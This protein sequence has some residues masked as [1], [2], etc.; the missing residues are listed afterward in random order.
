MRL[1]DEQ[2]TSAQLAAYRARGYVN[3]DL[4]PK[5]GKQRSMSALNF[6]TLWMQSVHNIPNYAAVGACLVMGCSPLHVMIAIL[7]GAL[8]TAVIMITNGVV[9]SRYGIPASMHL[10]TVYGARGA[11]LPGVLRGVVAALCWYG[12]QTYIGA[13]TLYILLSKLHPR[14]VSFG[15]EIPFIG[16][17]MPI[18]VCFVG[19]WLLNVLL[20]LGG[21][22]ILNKMTA[23]LSVMIYVVF[24]AMTLWALHVSGGFSVIMHYRMS[25]SK[26]SSYGFVLV[27]IIVVNMIVASWSAPIVSIADFT[28]HSRST[29][30]QLIG[31][32]A[33]F[34]LSYVLFAFTSV[35]IIIGGSIAYQRALPNVLD[36]INRWDNLVAI[37]IATL[38]LL[39]TTIVTNITGNIIPAA[40][41]ITALLPRWMTYKRAVVV[42]SIFSIALMPWRFMDNIIGFL[43]FI[44]ILLGPI[45]GVMIAD[46]Y[47]VRRR[48]IDLDQLYYDPRDAKHSLYAGTR[49]VAYV[50]TLI[51]LF[52]AL[53]GQII[54]FLSLCNRVSWIVGFTSGLIAEVLLSTIVQSLALKKGK[55]YEI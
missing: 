18:V 13:Q 39:L 22:V 38:L 20:G 41:Q 3:S 45:A 17:Y 5:V 46:Y 43:N 50:A 23:V 52:V 48:H 34:L 44:G 15:R 26:P 31:Q 11:Q 10:R 54:P 29:K 30:T 7:L 28:Q 51:G 4:L 40:Y 25:S 19:F 1:Q 14:F 37:A 36:I 8:F 12:I 55:Q 53:S 16:T 49:W 27:L 32:F 33:S 21:S 47:I 9:G 35:I 6:C 24:G 2:L 42:S